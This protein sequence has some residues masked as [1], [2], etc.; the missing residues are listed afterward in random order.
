[1][2]EWG[3]ESSQGDPVVRQVAVMEVSK[4]TLATHS[5]ECFKDPQVEASQLQLV[6]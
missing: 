6:F 5:E 2:G 1:M 4:G 3:R